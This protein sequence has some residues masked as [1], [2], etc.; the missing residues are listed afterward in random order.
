MDYGPV[1]SESIR[2]DQPEGS[3]VRKGLAIRLDHNTAMIFDT[4]LMRFSGGIA[5][6]WLDITETDYMSYKGSQI[7]SVEGRQVFFTTE[8]A[9][10]A[11]DGSFYGPRD[12]GM[13]NLPRDWA[14]Y[15]GFYRHGD[16]IVL[17]Y[18]VNETSVLEL[19]QAIKQR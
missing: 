2:K 17:S 19:P 9:G 7:A 8:I 13:G 6:G 1:L 10:W 12:D 14:H 11:N 3:L 4:D 16:Q 15:K 5:D 18:T